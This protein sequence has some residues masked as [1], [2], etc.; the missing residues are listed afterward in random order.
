MAA[1]AQIVKERDLT[2][3]SLQA[4]IWYMAVPMITEMVVLNVSMGLDTYWVG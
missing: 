3:G 4:S 1:E 2:S